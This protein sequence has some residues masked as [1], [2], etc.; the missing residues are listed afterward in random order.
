MEQA[1]TANAICV[2]DSSLFVLNKHDMEE[3]FDQF[4]EER[5]TIMGIAKARLVR[6]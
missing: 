3:L 5:E 6:Q 1:R 2:V 4:E